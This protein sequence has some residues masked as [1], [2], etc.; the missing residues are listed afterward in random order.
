MQYTLTC[1]VSTIAQ[2]YDASEITLIHIIL[3]TMAI[4]S[5]NKRKKGEAG[6]WDRSNRNV[7]PEGLLPPFPY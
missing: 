6:K 4:M 2:F 7:V 5:K 3:A 1:P